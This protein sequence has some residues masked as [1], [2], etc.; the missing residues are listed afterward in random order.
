MRNKHKIFSE[1]TEIRKYTPPPTNEDDEDNFV[2]DRTGIPYLYF[3]N[4]GNIGVEKAAIIGETMRICTG[5]GLTTSP[6]A[7]HESYRGRTSSETF[8][9]LNLG[10]SHIY[11]G[12]TQKSSKNRFKKWSFFF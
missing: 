11:K 9:M 10:T 8:M 3:N 5:K 4:T 7:T 2:R 12:K 6:E 1:N